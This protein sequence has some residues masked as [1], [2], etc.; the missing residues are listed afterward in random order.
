MRRL[1]CLVVLAACGKIGFDP[2]AGDGPPTDA[3]CAAPSAALPPPP[4]RPFGTPV[5][6][7]ELNDPAGTDDPTL[8]EDMLEICFQSSRGGSTRIWRA[9]R[10]TRAAVWSPPTPV[11]ELD[12]Y[13]ANTP[14]LSRD[15]LMLYFSAPHPTG[16]Q[17]VTYVTSRADRTSAWASTTLLDEL[18]TPQGLSGAM[19]FFDGRALMFS[20]NAGGGPG[21]SDLWLTFRGGSDCAEFGLVAPLPGQANSPDNEANGWIRNDG[22]AVVFASGR[23][24]SLGNGDIWTASRASLDV[25]FEPATSHPELDSTLPDD[26]PWLNDAM[27][28]IFY[29][30]VRN[31]L[32]ELYTA[33][34]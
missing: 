7:T 5:A 21:G 15:G 33:T 31:G 22:L 18:V 26:D 32:Q 19:P 2:L 28:T 30:S 9:T 34:R 23:T 3:T 24:G 17:A 20:T 12:T 13:Q 29:V 27:D 14:E 11:I 25:G 4:A 6:I 8:T 16:G 1:A 10:A